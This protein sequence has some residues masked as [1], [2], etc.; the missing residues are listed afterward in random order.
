MDLDI[1]VLCDR[2]LRM[3]PVNQFRDA[4]L[5][6]LRK[7]LVYLLEITADG[8]DGFSHTLKSC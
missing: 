8:L 4:K 2:M 1:V 7:V 6:E 5:G 3:T